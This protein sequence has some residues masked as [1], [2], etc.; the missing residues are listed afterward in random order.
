MHWAARDDREAPGQR[1][2]ERKIPLI[3]GGEAR[4][5]PALVGTHPHVKRL[6]G[7]EGMPRREGE[8]DKVV[9][10][11]ESLQRVRKRHRA[12]GLRIET[13][14]LARE[15]SAHAKGTFGKTPDG[16]SGTTRRLATLEASTQR[17]RQSRAKKPMRLSTST[18][19]RPSGTQPKRRG[20]LTPAGCG[21]GAACRAWAWGSSSRLQGPWAERGRPSA[22]QRGAHR[23]Q[24]GQ[25]RSR[26]APAR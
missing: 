2:I 14:R 19:P 13:R 3:P 20:T 17:E 4:C 25:H 21:A 1:L 22:T 23:S 24:P 12:M 9:E 11:S 26:R 6:R 8:T 15:E 7:E 18:P 16:Q 10:P 5:A